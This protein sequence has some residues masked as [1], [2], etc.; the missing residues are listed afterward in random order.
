MAMKNWVPAAS[1]LVVGLLAATVFFA[2][3]ST[4]PKGVASNEIASANKSNA[5][6]V[7]VPFGKKTSTT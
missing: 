6:K 2:D 5:E 1:G 4:G 3:F 7:Y